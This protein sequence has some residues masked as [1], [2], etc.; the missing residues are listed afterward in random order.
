[1]PTS[2]HKKSRIESENNSSENALRKSMNETQMQ[3]QEVKF[4][5]SKALDDGLVVIESS[6]TESDK[7]DTSS[8]SRNGI[9]YAVDADIRP[10]YDQVPFNE[11]STSSTKKVDI[12]PPN[13][14]NEDIT[15]PYECEQTL[16]VTAGIIFKCTQMIKRIAMASGDNTSGPAPQRK[17]RSVALRAVIL[18]DSPLSTSIDQDAP[19]ASIPSTQEQENSL[20][21]S[22]GFVESIKTPIFHDDPLHEPLHEDSTS[23]GSSSNMRQTHSL[24]EHLGRWTKDNPIANVIGN[25]SH[26][27]STRNKILLYCDNK[28]VIALCCNNVQHSR[29]KHIDIRYH[30]IKEQVENEIVELYFVW[31]KYQLDDIF[32]KPLPRER[33]NFLIEKLGQ[34]FEDL[35]LEHDILFII[36]DLGHSRDIIYLTDVNDLHQPWRAFAT[37]INKC[38]SG[39]ETGMDKILLSRAQILLGMFHKKNIDYVYLLWEDLLFQI[40]KKDAKKTNKMSYPRFTKIIIDYFICISRHEK[41]QVYGTRHPKELTDQAMLESK[42]YRT[43]YA[44]ASGEKTPKPKYVRK[45]ADSDSSPKQKPV[46][47]TK[48]TRLKLKAK[49]AKLDK[50]KQPIKKPKAKGLVV[51]SKVTLSDGIDT[52]SKVLVEMDDT[53]NDNEKTDSD[54][55]ESNRIKIPI[56]DQ[57][58]TE[59]YKEE[60]EKL[61]DKEMMYDDEDDKILPQAILDVTT[62]VI[63]KNVTESLEA[64]VL[65]RSSS[66]PQSLYEAAT[67]LSEFEL[68]KILIEKIEKNKSF[69]VADYKNELYDALVKSYNTDK[70][71]FKSYGEVVSLKRS[72]DDKDKDQDPSTRSDRGTERRESS[73]DA[74]SSRDS[75]SKENKSLSTSKDAS[76]SQH[77][78]SGKSAYS[79]EPRH[80]VENSG[81]QQDQEFVTGDN[82]E[83]PADKD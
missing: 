59:Y 32:T 43:Y 46:Q 34:K 64:A 48:G 12:E 80:T 76:Q 36:R 47:A 7:Q 9:T 14:L 35:P 2:C 4:D 77:K 69:V 75:K 52:Q 67:T 79:K 81:M 27:V 6:V 44:F 3:M 60:E 26:S 71:I 55:T 17:E 16:T 51:L 37:V 28:S 65:T 10:I 30:F 1:M 21:I 15:N 62:P 73:K 82:D 66:Q 63:E 23:Q 49:V 54:R 5:M 45:K 22:Q 13:G 83:Q 57:S 29:A 40:E 70:D 31:T 74:D 38:L 41:I 18:A 42:A 58:T 19:S 39:K 24:F 61:D 33:F 11:R 78:S 68:T 20:N 8:R 53:N 25:P 56:L 72:Q 50:M